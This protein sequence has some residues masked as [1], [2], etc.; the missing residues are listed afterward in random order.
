MYNPRFSFYNPET[1]GEV[2]RVLFRMQGRAVVVAGGTDL[3]P[4]MKQRLVTPEAVVCL[5]RL[6]YLNRIEEDEHF[7]RIGALTTIWDLERSKTV[8]QYFPA[9]SKT[10]R[11][12]AGPVHRAM[13]TVGGNI[14]LENR[15]SYYNQSSTWRKSV[16]SCFKTGGT[17][18]H[19]AKASKRCHAV[20]SA[21][22]APVLLL[23]AAEVAVAGTNGERVIPLSRFF[24]DD[25]LKGN[26]L[27]VD[28]LLISVRIP[29]PAEKYALEYIKMRPRESVDFPVVGTAVMISKNKD[30]I[31]VRLAFTGTASYPFTLDVGSFPG[32]LNRDKVFEQ[33]RKS[34]NEK[35]RPISKSGGS[36]A[37]KKQLAQ[38]SAI[39]GIEACLA[40]L[41]L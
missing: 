30:G 2:C 20:Y 40:E 19:V 31:D 27:A 16:E 11:L 9:L 38:V 10:A 41:K 22:L 13:G 24:V 25:G 3:V 23:L 8:K 15:C 34:V 39:D 6:K 18:C 17:V 33:V 37:Y 7:L 12:I 35:V 28:E 36:P 5:N 32:P 1:A 4:R 14:C 26:G 29:L 21:D